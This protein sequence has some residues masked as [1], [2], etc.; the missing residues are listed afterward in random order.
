MTPQTVERLAFPSGS[1]LELDIDRT[2]CEQSK[3][4]VQS[5]NRMNQ[6]VFTE[7]NSWKLTNTSCKFLLLNKLR[8]SSLN[9][10]EKQ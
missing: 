8:L 2:A 4:M 5:S 3:P 6:L 1:P 7:P 9:Y 10:E